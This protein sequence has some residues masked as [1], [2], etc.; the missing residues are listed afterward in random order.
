M[1]I[2]RLLTIHW[3]RHLKPY[4]CVAARANVCP[5]QA[6]TTDLEENIYAL[7]CFMKVGLGFS[8]SVQYII[9]IFEK[10]SLV[11]TPVCCFLFVPVTYMTAGELL[12]HHYDNMPVTCIPPWTPL[13]YSKTGVCRGIH[14]FLIFAPK[15]RL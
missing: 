5:S 12:H 7:S 1:T 14:I 10:N 15:H 13:L 6:N 11:D 9:Y 2:V 8:R 3:D 4:D